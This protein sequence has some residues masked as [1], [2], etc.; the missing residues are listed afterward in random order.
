MEKALRMMTDM[1]TLGFSG[2]ECKAYLKL[3]EEFPLNG[4]GLSKASGIP[5]S[6]IYEVLKNLIDKQMVFEQADEKSR[7]YYP[8]EPKIFI[9]K[10]KVRLKI[11]LELILKANSLKILRNKVRRDSYIIV[12]ETK[13]WFI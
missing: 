12:Q 6:R 13:K 1:K 10:L 9:K 11:Y 2:Y 4:Y 3:L 5:R 7:V 8:V